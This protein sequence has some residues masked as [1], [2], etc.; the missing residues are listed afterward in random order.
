MNNLPLEMS[1]VQ[2]EREIPVKTWKI[3]QFKLLAL[4]GRERRRPMNSST[5]E[6]SANE[7]YADWNVKCFS[8]K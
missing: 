4:N 5:P 1:G 3:F 2:A 8:W 7:I 6:K